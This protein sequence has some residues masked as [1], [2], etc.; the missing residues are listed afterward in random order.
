LAYPVAKRDWA[1][2]RR[3]DEGLQKLKRWVVLIRVVVGKGEGGIREIGN[4]RWIA[5]LA[6]RVFP[7][8][9]GPKVPMALP[10]DGRAAVLA[11][12]RAQEI[13]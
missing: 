6:A 7:S 10:V 13:G 4:E 5:L 2:E 11:G 1:E 12:K 8:C 9:G 3:F